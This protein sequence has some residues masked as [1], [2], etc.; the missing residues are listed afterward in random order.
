MRYTVRG[1]NTTATIT[2]VI[3][4]RKDAKESDPLKD[5]YLVFATNFSVREARTK[6]ANIPEVYRERWGIETGY[7][8]AKRIRPFTC[9]KNPS[10]RLVLFYFTMFLYNLW[11]ISGWNAGGTDGTNDVYMHPPITIDRMMG[12]LSTACKR[13]IIEKIV[14]DMFFAKVELSKKRYMAPGCQK[15][16]HGMEMEV[17]KFHAVEWKQRS[18]RWSGNRGCRPVFPVQTVYLKF[19]TCYAGVVCQPMIL[20]YSSSQ[21]LILYVC[22]K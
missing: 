7:R 21:S 4:P 17:R 11:V 14:A 19:H 3:V 5:R 9:S 10:V 18:F 1:K 2:L 15:T 16:V 20:T 13:M 22:T 12:A 8:V 6:L